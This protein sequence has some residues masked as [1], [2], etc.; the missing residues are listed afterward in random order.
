[1]V[2]C[3]KCRMYHLGQRILC[4][5]SKFRHYEC[6]K[7]CAIG[8]NYRKHILTRTI[9]TEGGLY[10]GSVIHTHMYMY[11]GV[12]SSNTGLYI[13]VI[14]IYLAIDN[15]RYIW[16]VSLLFLPSFGQ[17]ALTHILVGYTHI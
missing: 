8:E 3:T 14:Y 17:C 13:P 4:Y 2:C 11:M 16:E 10:V 12:C 6:D 1:M 7:Y 9:I 15:I 5:V